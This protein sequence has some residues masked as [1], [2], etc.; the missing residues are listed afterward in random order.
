MG[1][2]EKNKLTFERTAYTAR[3]DKVQSEPSYLLSFTEER[4]S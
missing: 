4:H 3:L 2:S 1:K